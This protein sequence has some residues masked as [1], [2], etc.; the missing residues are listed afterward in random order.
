MAYE[1]K[2][3]NDLAKWWVIGTGTTRNRLH[4]L[5]IHDCPLGPAI[6]YTTG[7]TAAGSEYYSTQAAANDSAQEKI[8]AG[9]W[10]ALVLGAGVGSLNAGEYFYDAG[11]T[12][13][14]VRLTGDAAPNATNQVRVHYLWDGS[15]AGPAIMTEVVEDA[16]YRI[17]LNAEIGDGSTTTTLTSLNEMIFG[18]TGI[19]FEV[20]ANA[21]FY[22]G[23]IINEYPVNGSMISL[24]GTFAFADG[25]DLFFYASK[26]HSRSNALITFT[27][28]TVT[29]NRTIF[30]N[31]G[32]NTGSNRYFKFDNT[33]TSWS[34]TA[35]SFLNMYRPTFNKSPLSINGIFVHNVDRGISDGAGGS[36]TMT[37]PEVGWVND[38][39]YVVGAASANFYVVDPI[40]PILSMACNTSATLHEQYTC[41]IHIADKDGADLAGATVDCEDQ[42]GTAVWT[43]GT[44]TTDANGDITEQTITYKQWAGTSET[45]T[46]YSPHKFTISK[47]GYETLTLDAITVD[48]PIDWHLEL[49]SAI[50]LDDSGKR[51][52]AKDD[53]RLRAI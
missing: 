1:A 13:L 19:P 2:T 53:G 30:S 18:D 22:M 27:T 6:Y 25:G 16:I 21:D 37:S 51:Y 50:R 34:A 32:Y 28:G 26:V 38:V 31:E 41:N 33:L 8:G 5:M 40:A 47:A 29:I 46:E 3:Q 17:H 45:L 42:T 52:Y 23:E 36:V 24:S 49:Q 12:R 14:Y 9:A 43:A 44:V 7:W 15:G 48:G 35:V 20:Q 10:A 11:T 4:D 39:E